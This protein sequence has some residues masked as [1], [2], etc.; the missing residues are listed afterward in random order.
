MIKKLSGSMILFLQLR[1]YSRINVTKTSLL[2]KLLRKQGLP[3]RIFINT[4]QSKEEI[5]LEFLKSDM[6]SWMKDVI[7]NYQRKEYSV[8]E[9]VDNWVA[10]LMDNKR[11]IKL[12]SILYEHLEKHASYES[13]LNFKTHFQKEYFPV[14]EYL[15]E[16][17][18]GFST[19][20]VIEFTNLQSALAIGLFQIDRSFG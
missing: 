17:I 1:D 14:V 15:S 4:S 13:L 16:K 19:D 5:F 11:L 8:I 6:K 20:K 2:F 18:E 12:I 7:N 3:D 9:F 10:L